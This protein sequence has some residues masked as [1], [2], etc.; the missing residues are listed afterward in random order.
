L[1]SI[2]SASTSALAL[3]G[4][5]FCYNV[6]IIVRGGVDLRVE[7]APNFLVKLSTLVLLKGIGRG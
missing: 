6:A 1:A 3:L 7:D 2:P 4:G 5:G